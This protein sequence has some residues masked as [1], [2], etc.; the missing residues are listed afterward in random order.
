MGRPSIEEYEILLLGYFLGKLIQYY[1]FYLYTVTFQ[2]QLLQ[3]II[4]Y[5]IHNVHTNFYTTAVLFTKVRVK[6]LQGEYCLN[7]RHF[8]EVF[9]A[10]YIFFF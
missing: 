4:L 2:L 9:Y 5:V 7:K 6:R 1:M 3:N 8:Y 10:I